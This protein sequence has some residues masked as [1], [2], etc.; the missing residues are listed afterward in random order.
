MEPVFPD[1]YTKM[2]DS[3]GGFS[4]F[5]S[6]GVKGKISGKCINHSLILKQSPDCPIGRSVIPTPS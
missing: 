6:L 2:C 4:C 3:R 5:S 1:I